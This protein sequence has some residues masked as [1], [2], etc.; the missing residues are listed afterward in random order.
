MDAPKYFSNFVTNSPGYNRI[1]VD[2][3]PCGIPRDFFE[4]HLNVDPALCG[5]VAGILILRYTA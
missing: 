1:C 2:P 3:D 4:L 5:M